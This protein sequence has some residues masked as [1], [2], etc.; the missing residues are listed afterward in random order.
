MRSVAWLALGAL[1]AACAVGAFEQGSSFTAEP[2]DGTPSSIR[3][4]SQG[5]ADATSIAVI[6]LDS[7]TELPLEG[8]IVVIRCDCMSGG[9]REASTTTDGVVVFEDTPAGDYSMWVAHGDGEVAG[10]FNMHTQMTVDVR[11]L[12]SDEPRVVT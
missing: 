2:R 9:S 7:D 11:V 10:G 4:G 8:A 1:S 12:L 5:H 3:V 6:V